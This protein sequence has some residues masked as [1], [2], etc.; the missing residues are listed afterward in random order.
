MAVREGGSWSHIS[1]PWWWAD[2][3]KRDVMNHNCELSDLSPL[4][5]SD[6]IYVPVG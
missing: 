5:R 4:H 6:Q 1:W 3:S 2:G